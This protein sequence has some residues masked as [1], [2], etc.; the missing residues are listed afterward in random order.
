MVLLLYYNIGNIYREK[1]YISVA[2][3]FYFK[4]RDLFDQLKNNNHKT[5]LAIGEVYFELKDY[6]KALEYF[7][8]ELIK[9]KDLDNKEGISTAL[10]RI[11]NVYFKLKEYQ[12]SEDFCLRSLEIADRSDLIH[13]KNPIMR[14]FTRCIKN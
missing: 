14:V 10:N 8:L 12:K 6:E 9:K 1:K 3:E 13:Q 4:S 11:G 7:D 2:L 5:I